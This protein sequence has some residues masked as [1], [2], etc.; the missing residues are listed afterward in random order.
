ML[1]NRSDI[2]TYV[3]KFCALC[4]EHC[5]TWQTYLKELFADIAVNIVFGG[6]ESI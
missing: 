2:F 6:I 4:H 1:L 3:V 5:I